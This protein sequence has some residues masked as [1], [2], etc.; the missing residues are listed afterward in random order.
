MNPVIYAF[1][2]SRFRRGF[3]RAL[4]CVHLGA[5]GRTSGAHEMSGLGMGGGVSTSRG[6][7]GG[8][9]GI[10]MNDRRSTTNQIYK[11]TSVGG[12]SV[13]DAST[14]STY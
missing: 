2:S 12:G 13:G 8:A 1:L 7:G 4:R 11:F 6:G 5:S 14:L 9:G 3:R 10:S